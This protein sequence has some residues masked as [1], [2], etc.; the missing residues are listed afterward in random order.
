VYIRD[1]ADVWANIV[2]KYGLTN[3]DLR[4]FVAQGDQHADFAFAGAVVL[5][6]TVE[7]CKAGSDSAIDTRKAFS[8]AL[9]SFIGL[10]PHVHHE[11]HTKNARG[12]YPTP[13]S[14]A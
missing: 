11:R 12:E 2:A 10:L 14:L 4:A 13:N 5:V 1:K 7:L 9:Q 3:G 8:A 6:S